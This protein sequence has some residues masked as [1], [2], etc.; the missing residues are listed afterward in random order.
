MLWLF[1]VYFPHQA[2]T[3]QPTQ[4]GPRRGGGRPLPGMAISVRG[5]AQPRAQRLG[6]QMAWRCWDR[7]PLP[8]RFSA[9]SATRQIPE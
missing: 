2:G 1:S 3:S 6:Q 9:L 8:E 7:H 4:L 5:P